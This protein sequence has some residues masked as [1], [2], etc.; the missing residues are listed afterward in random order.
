[1]C[2][3][4]LNLWVFRENRR[5]LAGA[6]ARCAL[7]RELEGLRAESSR[8]RVI[9]LLLRAGE[10]ECGVAD[11]A[12]APLEPWARLTDDLARALVSPGIL[13]RPDQ[14]AGS[15]EFTEV[16]EQ[17]E[18]SPPEGFA[19]YALHPLAYAEV[20]SKIPSLSDSVAVVG[21][22]SIGTT[23]S[24]VVVAAARAEGKRA[25]RNTVRPGGHPYN[26]L[27]TLSP[28]QAEFVRR[29]VAADSAFL[30]VDEGPGLSGSSFLS[31]AEALERA[32][33]ARERIVLIGSHLPN[34][35]DLRAEDA[36]RRARRFCWIAVSTE[37]RSP[38]QAGDFIGGGQWRTHLFTH[39]E[40]WPAAWITFERLKYFSC[41][42]K[43][44]FKFIGL[45]HYGQEVLTR[46]RQ[47]TAA[48]FGP[49]P[50]READGFAW[51]PWIAGRS[52]MANDLS[53]TVIERLAA[54]C[55]FRSKAFAASHAGIDTLQ[56]MAEHNW[57]Q[58]KNPQILRL[59][60][61][62]PAVVD[63]R[64]QPHEWLLTHS[65]EMLKTDSGAHG[66]DHFFPG[67]TDIAWDLAGAIV[68]W[69]MT[70]QQSRYFLER[71]RA[72]SGDDA[73]SRIGDFIAAYRAF[74]WAYCRMAANALGG[75]EEQVR[76]ER[77]AG[78]YLG[79][80]VAPAPEML[81]S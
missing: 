25:E 47:V 42:D 26:R 62:R 1:M 2:A 29:H 13:L 21:I 64:M 71:Y 5:R 35:D 24:A 66:D 75:S 31:V 14:L 49:T 53:P 19:Y 15:L 79:P 44:L 41:A 76:L 52:M 50:A 12:S 17:I 40:D 16:P 4:A 55:A 34:V 65:G 27:M 56:Q 7:L 6:Q 80:V 48:G 77:A 9:R 78:N 8:E 11:A 23:L 63:G 18:V 69:K 68:E 58:T 36:P 22:R 45:G 28:Q 81:V 59:R 10:M 37:P 54:Y 20:L 70:P 39:R 72:E 43:K 57:A 73:T 32:G 3:Q 61:E 46:E 30:V 60:L 67:P 74:R 38:A 33:V 51:Y